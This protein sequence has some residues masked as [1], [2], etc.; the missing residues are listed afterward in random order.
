[1]P[2]R[3]APKAKSKQRDWY[4][5]I[6]EEILAELEELLRNPKAWNR[7]WKGLGIGLPYNGLTGRAYNG[8][9]VWLLAITGRADRRWFTFDQAKEAV[10]Y[11][12]NSKWKGRCDTYKGVQKWLWKGDGDD[13]HYGIRK[14]EKGRYV[15]FWKFIRKFED[16]YGKPVKKPTPVQLASGEVRQVGSIPLMRAYTV[17]NAEQVDGLKAEDIPT[18]DPAD[19]YMQA[20]A[21]TEILGVNLNHVPGVGAAYYSPKRDEIVLPAPGQFDTV[22]DYWATTLHEVIHWTGRTD[23]LDRDFKE[24]FGSDARAFEELTAELGSAFL[25][26]HLGIEGKL[27]HAE[28]VAAWVS[29]LQNDKYA[30]FAAAREAQKAVDFILAGGQTADGDPE[31]TEAGDTAERNAA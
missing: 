25:C 8:M 1:M 17:F 3:P 18:V 9:N 6:T 10:G 20:E 15:I 4:A 28:Y 2:R 27:Q 29:R 13:P 24:R 23:R 19:K 31:A 16:R 12:R 30:V 14:G 11:K 5:E 7:P 26:A 22:E 21:L